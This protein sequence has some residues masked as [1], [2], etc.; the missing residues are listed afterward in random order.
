M[1][2]VSDTRMGNDMI[3]QEFVIGSDRFLVK[4]N[5]YYPVLVP[6]LEDDYPSRGISVIGKAKVGDRIISTRLLC[7]RSPEL[8]KTWLL[9]GEFKSGEL[10]GHEVLV[11]IW[12]EGTPIPKTQEWMGK[13]LTRPRNGS[14]GHS[15][16]EHSGEIE[17]LN[18]FMASQWKH[19]LPLA[20]AV[21]LQY[22][23]YITN[24]MHFIGLSIGLFLFNYVNPSIDVSSYSSSSWR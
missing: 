10:T 16:F 20:A 22:E 4:S 9:F 15:A 1:H 11:H 13:L 6:Q 19:W 7:Q 23:S 12:D 14:P 2:D 18:I 21:R 5:S 8:G 3:G 17:F 24:I